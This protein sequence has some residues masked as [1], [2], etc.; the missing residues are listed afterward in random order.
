MEKIHPSIELSIESLIPKMENILGVDITGIT[1]S[2]I[3]KQ[4]EAKLRVLGLNR[5]ADALIAKKVGVYDSLNDK[6]IDPL[7]TYKI[8]EK[9]CTDKKDTTKINCDEQNKKIKELNTLAILNNKVGVYGDY[10]R[11]SSTISDI[12]KNFISDLSK[13]YVILKSLG[14][15]K[16]GAYVFL[17]NDLQENKQYILKLYALKILD[18]IEDKDVREIFTTC[19]LSTSY[20]FPIVHDYG[21]TQYNSASPFWN[22]FKN[23]YIECVPD[24]NKVKDVKLYTRVYYLVTEIAGGKEL[25]DKNLAGYKPHELISILYQLAIIFKNAKDK[26]PYFLHNDLHPGNIYID[27]EFKDKLIYIKNNT[28]INGPKVSI[29]D[30]DL[31]LTD[32]YPKNLAKGRQYMGKYLVQEAMIKLLNIYF[33][34]NN[35][36]AIIEYTSKLWHP[37]YYVTNNDDFRMWYIYKVLFELVMITN[38][39][40]I[41]NQKTTDQKYAYNTEDIR[42]LLEQK[43]NDKTAYDFYDFESFIKFI[44]DNNKL[45]VDGKDYF[46][47]IK[48]NTKNLIIKLPGYDVYSDMDSYENDIKPQLQ[49]KTIYELKKECDRNDN[50]NGFNSQGWIKFKISK[51]IKPTQGITLYVKQPT[52]LKTKSNIVARLQ[53]IDN[54]FDLEN[55]FDG[56]DEDTNDGKINSLKTLIEVLNKK[57]GENLLPIDLIKFIVESIE[58][59]DKTTYEKTYLHFGLHNIKYGVRINFGKDDIIELPFYNKGST[60]NIKLSASLPKADRTI[61]IFVNND[62][63]EI[64]LDNIVFNTNLKIDKFEGFWITV[65]TT[66]FGADIKKITIDKI[67]GEIKIYNKSNKE[68]TDTQ[69]RGIISS[70]INWGAQESIKQALNCPGISFD[71]NDFMRNVF[72]LIEVLLKYLY[73]TESI[74][75]TT[76]IISNNPADSTNLIYKEKKINI[77][78]IINNIRNNLDERVKRYILKLPGVKSK[79]EKMEKNEELLVNNLK[80]NYNKKEFERQLLNIYK[81]ADATSLQ[82]MINN[83]L[84]Q[85]KLISNNKELTYTNYQTKSKTLIKD[86]YLIINELNQKDISNINPADYDKEKVNTITKQYTKLI[87][88]KDTILEK[89]INPNMIIQYYNNN[90]GDTI[91][92]K[93]I[94]TKSIIPLKGSESAIN[95]LE[96]QFYNN[97]T[98]ISDNKILPLTEK[99]TLLLEIFNN[100]N[101]SKNLKTNTEVELTTNITNIKKTLV[102]EQCQTTPEFNAFIKCIVI[103]RLQTTYKYMIGPYKGYAVENYLQYYISDINS[104]VNIYDDI[105]KFTNDDLSGVKKILVRTGGLKLMASEYNTATIKE[106]II[107]DNILSELK[108]IAGDDEISIEIPTSS[109]LGNYFGKPIIISTIGPQ[110]GG[111]DNTFYNE[112][113]IKYKAK[114]KQFKKQ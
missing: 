16:S 48:E 7:P 26:L 63:F 114:Y 113:Y 112:K 15:G 99:Y 42:Q 74:K 9:D 58:E 94:N 19:A 21:T 35:T 83:L 105:I 13:K 71:L 77:I 85:E 23:N 96:H 6:T 76:L 80:I 88:D 43:Y 61:S 2:Y 86:I 54:I 65:A 93:Y 78:D 14:G 47:I 81:V 98:D 68:N 30:F 84:I 66:I 55:F 67:T 109:F 57:T 60:I 32:E 107:R 106:N 8:K 75:D 1:Q 53:N 33:G 51:E 82:G 72:P 39:S 10:L 59:L 22:K 50:C 102:F 37:P 38:I 90:N 62:L 18:T 56:N 31:T 46:A 5:S 27:D 92:E 70:L 64:I 12:T 103:G 52:L 49:N 104:I 100:P 44:N 25:N 29:I 91:L 4:L 111:S 20:G 45:L 34:V 36:I 89:S 79:I 28:Y 40:T 73:D 17:V 11:C 69:L 41:P 24:K 108:K 97:I 3:Y 95:A 87:I 110:A 101:I